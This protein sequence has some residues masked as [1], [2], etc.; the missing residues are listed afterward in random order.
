MSYKVNALT[1]INSVKAVDN[2]TIT[3]SL[4]EQNGLIDWDIAWDLKLLNDIQ[5]LSIE[6]DITNTKKVSIFLWENKLL[7]N[8]TYSLL[9]VF[10][11]EGSIDFETKTTLDSVEVLNTLVSEWQWIEHI[12]IKDSS[13]IEVYYVNTVNSTDFEF[14]L[15]SSVDIAKVTKLSNNLNITTKDTLNNNS[16]Y[17]IMLMS[18]MDTNSKSL[19][20]TDWIYDFMTS[21]L[22]QSSGT[23]STE[24]VPNWWIVVVQSEVIDESTV[25]WIS[26]NAAETPDT[27]AETNV[28]IALTFILTSFVFLRRKVF[29]R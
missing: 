26:L 14:K 6:K 7:P 4:N 8:K 19:T 11:S 17:I 3:I 5:V 29:K 13:T 21:S 12:F 25:E 18:L 2:K 10:W 27:W 9:T 1:E 28:L 22:A 15:L 23:P 16:S 20:F 24:V